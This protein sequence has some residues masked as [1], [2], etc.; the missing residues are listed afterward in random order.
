MKL[1]LSPN[2]GFYFGYHVITSQEPSI[3]LSEFDRNHLC[4]ESH[5]FLFVGFVFKAREGE[6][7]YR[8]QC[9][10][11]TFYGFSPHPLLYETTCIQFCEGMV[12]M[13]CN[14]WP[15]HLTHTTQH[16]HTLTEP[17]VDSNPTSVTN[18]L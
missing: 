6:V 2:A 11:K 5:P 1:I 18:D 15:Y 17:R 9:S 10:Y 16:T 12:A 4:L 14:P 3:L 8:Y 13:F 7:C